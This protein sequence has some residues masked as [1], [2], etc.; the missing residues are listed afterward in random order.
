MTWQNVSTPSALGNDHVWALVDQHGNA[1]AY[2]FRQ[3]DGRW[4]WSAGD[5][6]GANKNR[7]E[8]AMKAAETALSKAK[9]HNK[10]GELH[11][12]KRVSY[13]AYN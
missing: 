9:T 13:R 6:S 10:G 1:K 12:E 11:G 2:V 4:S 7:R 5:K 8:Q 3:G